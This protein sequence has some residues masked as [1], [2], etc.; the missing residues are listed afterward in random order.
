MDPLNPLVNAMGQMNLNARSTNFAA[1]S[2]TANTATEPGPGLALAEQGFLDSPIKPEKPQEERDDD[3]DELEEEMTYKSY[4]PAK[5][6]FG[7]DHPDPVVENATLAAVLP[8][9]VTYNLALPANI[10][11]EGK[12]SNLQL[13]AIVYGSQRFAVDLPMAATKE[14]GAVNLSTEGS[15][16]ASEAD[17]CLCVVA[18]CLEVSLYIQII[19]LVLQD[20]I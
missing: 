19:S 15:V 1:P 9:D 20:L 3:L 13:E 5:L 16:L 10:I 8:P 11:S 4:R 7:R 14:V 2:A 6:V 12:L 18:S 17:R